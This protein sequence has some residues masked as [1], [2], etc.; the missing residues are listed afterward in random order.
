MKNFGSMVGATIVSS[1]V[2]AASAGY[3]S[4]ARADDIKW[5]D[6]L[7]SS[8]V[9]AAIAAAISQVE[10]CSKKPLRI[11]EI[12]SGNNKRS[13]V[14]TCAGTEDEEGSSILH[15]ERFGDGPWRPKSFD[16]AG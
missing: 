11:E 7:Q 14:F 6:Y 12:K 3:G 13:L 2:A 1:I 10:H 16:L 4:E 9:A 8:Y 5:R 15:L